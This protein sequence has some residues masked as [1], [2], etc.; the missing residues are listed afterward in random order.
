MAEGR[1]FVGWHGKTRSNRGTTGRAQKPL[2]GLSGCGR[3]VHHV[4]REPSYVA[5]RGSPG[6][7]SQ[8]RSYGNAPPAVCLHSSPPAPNPDPGSLR[9]RKGSGPGSECTRGT[10]ES[11]RGASC[12]SHAGTGREVPLSLGNRNCCHGRSCIRKGASLACGRA[13][14]SSLEEPGLQLDDGL[15]GRAL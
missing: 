10:R 9:T 14:D 6:R 5:F 8:R 7:G 3:T 11:C 13:W 1:F 15:L 4:S 2:E 12:A